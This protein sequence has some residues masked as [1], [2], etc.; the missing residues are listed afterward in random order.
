LRGTEAGAD[1]VL[2]TPTTEANP[3][4]PA[5][6]PSMFAKA[7]FDEDFRSEG[8]AD[9]RSLFAGEAPSSGF[10]DW[11]SADVL[12]GLADSSESWMPARLEQ[13]RMRATPPAG[14]EGSFD[15]L[16]F[17]NLP[18]GVEFRAGAIGRSAGLRPSLSEVGDS[19]V[20]AGFTEPFLPAPF[21]GLTHGSPDAAPSPSLGFEPE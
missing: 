5:L 12:S 8:I 7:Y 1:I 20:K 18:A 10:T 3:P 17:D 4:S 6:D 16:E 13:V 19:Y 15:D 14:P 21:P 2:F 9:L 11:L